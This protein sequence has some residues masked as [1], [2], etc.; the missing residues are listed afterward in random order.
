MN[1][2]KVVAGIDIGGT[3]S[4]LGL[5]DA[6][7]NCLVKDSLP[8]DAQ[9]GPDILFETIF[10]RIDELIFRH[11]QAL[12][13]IG[14]GVGAP[15][16]NYYSGT[17]E[18]PVNL[19]WGIVNVVKK[20]DEHY[21]L[22]GAITNDANAAALGEMEFGVAKGMQNFIEITLGTGLGSGIIVNGEL[23]YGQDGF[24]GELGHI[25]VKRDGRK[26]GCG[27]LGCLEAY[28]SATGLKR[29]A[30]TLMAKMTVN[31]TLRLLA[32]V[33]LTSK[34]VFDAAVL[35]DELARECFQYTATF[36][37][38]ALADCVAIFSPEAFIFTGGMAKAGD[39]LLE[40]TKQI[41]EQSL[42]PV[43]RNKV[44]LL[45]SGMDAGDAAILGSAALI[46]HQKHAQG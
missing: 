2:I 35:G 43:F 40:P 3:N 8:T 42:L 13:L 16:A 20:I 24:A 17:I 46:W 39:L 38:R 45:P 15:N 7:G 36:L 44:K 21:H 29:T 31:S 18:N 22:P 34:D 27:R 37:G 30:L 23:V 5:V 41:M 9:N 12:D 11:E 4:V 33:A 25:T 19:G 1:K 14:I 6:K 26:C 28:V 32:P 10:N